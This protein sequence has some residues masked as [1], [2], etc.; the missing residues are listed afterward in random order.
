M[1]DHRGDIEAIGRIDAIPT[2]LDVICRT[3]GMGFAAVARVTEDRWIACQVLDLIAFGLTA[4]DELEVESTICHEIRQTQAPVVINHVAQS[5]LYRDHATPLRYGFQSYISVPIRTSDGAFFGTLCAIDPRP[6]RVE[7]PETIGMFELFAQLIARQL[8]ADEQLL[9]AHRQ[10]ADQ[11]SLA[12]LREQFIAVL[13]HDLR[14]P[15]ASID[16]GTR[17]LART[18]LDER[19]AA[20]LNLMQGSVRRMKGLIDDLMDFARG[21][22]GGGLALHISAEEP[23]GPVLEQVISELRSVH[24]E[25]AI[26][27]IGDCG[28][29]FACDRQRIGQ[30]LSN[31]L[32]NALTHGAQGGRVEIEARRQPGEFT[33]A[34]RNTGPKIAATALDGLFEPFVRAQADSGEQGLGLGLY[35]AA[36]IAQAHGGRIDVSSTDAETVFTFRM[37]C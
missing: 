35:I 27:T 22:L 13:G 25:I 15:I 9:S 16:A 5:D 17:T 2:M 19:A 4:G 14:N 7:N 18:P 36:Q 6:A 12:Q 8:E 11:Q 1:K 26:A 21:R 37:P 28:A 23:L 30:L 29:P 10:I 33:L 34:V 20:V 32:G 24:P 31:L 3:T